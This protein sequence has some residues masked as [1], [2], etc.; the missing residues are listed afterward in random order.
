MNRSSKRRA[1]VFLAAA[2]C[3][4]MAGLAPAPARAETCPP[5]NPVGCLIR[6]KI[7]KLECFGGCR[8]RKLACLGEVRGEARACRLECRLDGGTDEEISACKR[9]CTA[10]AL[11]KAREVCKLGKP[12]CV[13][14][15]HPESC[16]EHCG[17]VPD[18][19]G[20]AAASVERGDAPM[21]EPPVDRECL[22]ECARELRRCATS[23][24]EDA[25][26]CLDTC[27][28]LRGWERLRCVTDCVEDAREDAKACKGDFREC[29][30]ECGVKVDEVDPPAT[31]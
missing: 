14:L 13:R 12:S 20:D 25:T 5:E 8:A 26:E 7:E 15:C 2:L 27:S 18:D 16:R 31:E 19:G 4:L 9:E 21:C 3:W 10:N 29:A 24:H 17:L 23:V 28:D 22:G 1:T 30:G 6:C 11:S